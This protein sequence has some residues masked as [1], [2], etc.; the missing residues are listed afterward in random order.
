MPNFYGM[1]ICSF[2]ILICWVGLF[3]IIKFFFQP[4]PKEVFIEA[5]PERIS[6]IP[7][8][9]EYQVFVSTE[10]NA[11]TIPRV[12]RIDDVDIVMGLYYMVRVDAE[13]NGEVEAA[14]KA[15]WF[16]RAWVPS[17]QFAG[18]LPYERRKPDVIMT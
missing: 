2:F 9:K 13:L 16:E 17:S 15:N 10:Y 7:L 12:V 8:G 3:L 14:I 6:K 5:L 4:E 11:Y 18:L 1:L